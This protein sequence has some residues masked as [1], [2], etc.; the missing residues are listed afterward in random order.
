M[1]RVHGRALAHPAA[2]A[3]HRAVLPEAQHAARRRAVR[4]HRAVED[5]LDRLRRGLR[6]RVDVRATSARWAWVEYVLAQGG[7]AEGLAVLDAVPDGGSFRAY[8]RA[9]AGVERTP[10]RALPVAAAT[11]PVS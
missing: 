11:A 7:E 6:G 5:R 9:F 4:G 2:R 1:H 8:E 3:R 10:R